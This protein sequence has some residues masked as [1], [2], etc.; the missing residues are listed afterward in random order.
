[1]RL[2]A[3]K[4]DVLTGVWAPPPV[5]RQDQA[6]TNDETQDQK[7]KDTSVGDAPPGGK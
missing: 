1:M 3:P 2:Y 4:S 6:M 7:D 5:T